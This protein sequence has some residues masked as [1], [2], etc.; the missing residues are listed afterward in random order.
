M[1][2]FAIKLFVGGL[3]FF[4]AGMIIGKVYFSKTIT[5]IKEVKNC[6]GI[7]YPK[8][9][10]LGKFCE[11]FL[12]EPLKTIQSDLKNYEQGFKE[13]MKKGIQ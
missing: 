7:C 1:K 11:G 12:K 13:G 4:L 10:D 5:E 2:W 9:F 6:E 3:C 8:D